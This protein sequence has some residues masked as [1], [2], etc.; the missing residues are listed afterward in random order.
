MKTML[1]MFVDGDRDVIPCID[2]WV[3]T[4]AEIRGNGTVARGHGVLRIERK[5]LCVRCYMLSNVRSWGY[6]EDLEVND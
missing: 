2:R 1:I 5:G 6:K 4:D 3:I